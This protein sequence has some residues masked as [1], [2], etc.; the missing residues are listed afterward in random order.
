MF[1]P[2]F[3][4]CL[5]FHIVTSGTCLLSGDDFE[6]ITLSKGDFALV[7][8]GK[9]HRLQTALGVATPDVVHLPQQMLTERYSLLKHGGG[10]AATTLVCGVVQFD[11]PFARYVLELLPPVIHLGSMSPAMS[12]WMESTLKLMVIEARQLRTGG[13]TIITRLADI[14]V[15]Q[16]IRNWIQDGAVN[17]TGWLAAL[18]DKQIGQAI[19]RIHNDL[20]FSWSVA[21][22]ASSVAMSRSAFAA[23]FSQLVG[24]TPMQYVTRVRMEAASTTLKA[25]KTTLAE[26]ATQ[27]GY[28]S[29]AAFSRAFKRS[30]GLSPGIARSQWANTPNH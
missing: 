29:E 27:L 17:Q 4:D 26:L 28:Q 14:L 13:E 8:N 18:K 25:G 20:A 1:M 22:L 10:G 5:W 3:K 30:V 6:P 19:M 23:R 21:S 12:E 2:P 11:H 9:G 16:A 15:I 7:P 24:E